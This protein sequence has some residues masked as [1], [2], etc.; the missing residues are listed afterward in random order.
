MTLFQFGNEVTCECGAVV[1]LESRSDLDRLSGEELEILRSAERRFADGRR[2]ESFRLAADRI[3]TLILHTDMP[4]IDIEIA[5]ESFRKEVLSEFPDRGELFDAI[6]LSR[7]RRLWSQFRDDEEG[8]LDR[9][10]R[11]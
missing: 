2:A 9:E 4:R 7:F 5:I 6:Y 11:E 3:A 8:L 10:A 1:R